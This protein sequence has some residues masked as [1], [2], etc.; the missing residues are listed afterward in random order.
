MGATLVPG[1]P[2]QFARPGTAWRPLAEPAPRT[3]L[4][5]VH[6]RERLPATVA[7]LLRVVE[8]LWPDPD[9]AGER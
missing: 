9:A 8:R 2:G 7:A 5:L 4:V 1:G 6:R 3:Q